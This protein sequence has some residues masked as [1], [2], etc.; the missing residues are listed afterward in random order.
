M[1]EIAR[2]LSQ[3]FGHSFHWFSPEFEGSKVKEDFEGIKIERFGFFGLVHLWTFFRFF[4]RWSQTSD[5][6]IEDYHGVSL[7]ISTYIS[8]PSVILVH[9]VAG[10]IWKQMWKFPL[11]WIGYYMEKFIFHFLK[12]SWFIAVSESTRRD[13]ILHGI[14]PARI[15]LISE[16]SNLSPVEKPMARKERKEQFVFVGRVC[17]M[18]R[19]DLLLGAFAELLTFYPEARLVLAGKMDP[20]FQQEYDFLINSLKLSKN[21]LFKGFVS[22]EEKT[23]LMQESLAL[24]SASMHEGFGLIVVEA[25]SQGT[26]ALTFNVPG[27]RDL[28]ENGKNG[29]MVDYPEIRSFAGRMREILGMELEKYKELCQSSLVTSRKYSWDQTADDFQNIISKITDTPKE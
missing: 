4:P 13:L 28:I 10:D 15:F 11:S 26:P 19:V 27:Y 29:F 7:G 6:Y 8:K 9:E 17:K 2:R 20:D 24:V 12:N 14:S 21:V 16:G 1:T 18:K 25:N 22:T 5:L 23:Q 3:K